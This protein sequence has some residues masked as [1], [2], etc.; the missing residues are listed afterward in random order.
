MSDAFILENL[1]QR[2]FDKKHQIHYKPSL[3][4]H[5][6]TTTKPLGNTTTITATQH[7]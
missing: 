3:T 7:P 4:T 2:Q 5:T 6:T 1:F